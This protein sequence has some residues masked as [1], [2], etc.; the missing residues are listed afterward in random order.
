MLE[1]CCEICRS[2]CTKSS[3]LVCTQNQNPVFN[4]LGLYYCKCVT[5]HWCL[6]L[7][8]RDAIKEGDGENILVDLHQEHLNHLCKTSIQSLG[9]N[10]T[11]MVVVR[12]N[13]ALGPLSALL[14]Q[15]DS[16]RGRKWS[17]SE[18]S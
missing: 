1:S 13:K 14:Q 18:T 17:T 6:Y 11:E 2:R 15:F 3:C 12:C 5:N 4:V 7:E 8:I 10:N 9:T 16:H